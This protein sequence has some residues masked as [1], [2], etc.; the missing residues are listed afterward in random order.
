MNGTKLVFIVPTSP[1]LYI[2]WYWEGIYT[3]VTRDGTSAGIAVKFA[4]DM[5]M[6]KIYSHISYML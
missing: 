2:E 6:T 5:S 1:Y 4:G 3:I